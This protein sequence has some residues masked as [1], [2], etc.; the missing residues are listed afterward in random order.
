M[1]AIGVEILMG[2]AWVGL[3]RNQAVKPL[4]EMNRLLAVGFVGALLHIG[5]KKTVCPVWIVCYT[6]RVWIFQVSTICK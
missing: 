3:F 5:V 6:D 2:G 1:E 4:K